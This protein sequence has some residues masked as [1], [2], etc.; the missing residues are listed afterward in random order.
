MNS[1][2]K[3]ALSTSSSEHLLRRTIEPLR[4]QFDFILIDTPP[5]VKFFTLSAIMA[6]DHI[7][8]TTQSTYLSMHGIEQ[9][10]LIINAVRKNRGKPTIPKILLTLHDPNSTAAQAIYNN[11]IQRYADRILPHPIVIDEKI[12]EAQILKQSLYQYAPTSPAAQAYLNTAKH[13]I[14]IYN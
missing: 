14:K 11:I 9:I 12:Q 2:P 10:E 5:S 1:F 7:I 4:N 3:Y 13:L 6:S 8:V